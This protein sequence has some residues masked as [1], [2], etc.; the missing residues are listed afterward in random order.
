MAAATI[1]PDEGQ[2]K[3]DERDARIAEL[4]AAL[5]DAKAQA[6]A[7]AEAAAPVKT[8]RYQHQVTKSVVNVDALTASQLSPDWKP[9]KK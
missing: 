2:D 5:A 7:D 9:F 3:T 4:E 8:S 1:R 6:D